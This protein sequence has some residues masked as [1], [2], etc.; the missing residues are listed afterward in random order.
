MSVSEKKSLTKER[1]E[2]IKNIMYC[3]SIHN[4]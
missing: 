4:L 3:Y 2:E 1:I